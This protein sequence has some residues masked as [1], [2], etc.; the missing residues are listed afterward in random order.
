ARAVL[1]LAYGLLLVRV[2]GRRVFGKWSALDFVL[3]I[4]I[5]SNLS[6]ALTG[7]APLGGTM[8][9]TTLLVALHWLLSHL[10]ARIP[11]VSHLL[12][13]RAI[14]LARRGERAD[15]D[16]LRHAIS[17]ADFDE[18]LRERG[19]ATAEEAERITLEPSGKITIL[20]RKD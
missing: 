16:R 20:K 13:G 10:S 12:E 18:A 1:I 5:G 9:A 19:I 7:G 11:A 2:A 8:A 17:D 6:R 14:V 4:I 15:H 3:A